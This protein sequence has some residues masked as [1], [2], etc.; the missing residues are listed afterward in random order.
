MKRWAWL[1]PLAAAIILLNGQ[2]SPARDVALLQ[3]VQVIRVSD[4]NPLIK[5]ETDTGEWG[6]GTTL[7][8][9]MAQLKATAL[10]EIFF[11]TADYL[12]IT[13]EALWLIPQLGEYLRPG[14]AVCV[15][16][17]EADL[18]QVGDFLKIHRPQITLSNYQAGDH[19]LP[20]LQVQEGRMVLVS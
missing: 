5:V 6:S 1:L 2:P 4:E 15:E 10:A 8:E 16:R 20:E 18:A 17:G 3:P 11:D 14:C 9:A 19:A 12:L 13:P 7:A